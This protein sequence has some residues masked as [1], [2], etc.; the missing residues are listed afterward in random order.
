MPQFSAER[1]SEYFINYLTRQYSGNARHVYRVAPWLGL[2]ALGI[3]KIK[4]SW[5]IGSS[6]QLIFEKG[7]KRYKARYEHGIKRGGQ[8]GGIEIVEVAK[9]PGSPDITI[10][11]QIG[12]LAE[13]ENFYKNPKI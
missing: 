8:R 9:S 10:A 1:M 6:R 4:D 3:E 11:K 12:S 7:K 13:A 5:R 2:I